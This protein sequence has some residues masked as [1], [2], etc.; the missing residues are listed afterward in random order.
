MLND[1]EL[2][3]VVVFD[4][5][6]LSQARELVVRLDDQW[7]CHAYEESNIT[8]V[9]VF[10]A[11][12]NDSELAPLLRTVEDWVTERS[13]G[14]IM[15]WIDGRGYLLRARERAAAAVLGYEPQVGSRR[16]WPDAEV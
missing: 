16:T 2:T 1:S 14:G 6:S 3:D 8:S 12:T 4:V 7:A 11:P 15:F 10:I 9:S 13:L 5:P